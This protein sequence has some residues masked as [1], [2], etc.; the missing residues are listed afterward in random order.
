MIMATVPAMHE[1]VH[2]RACRQEQPRQPG[3]DV[4]PVLGNQEKSADDGKGEEH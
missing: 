2:E 3:Q 1:N 4:G